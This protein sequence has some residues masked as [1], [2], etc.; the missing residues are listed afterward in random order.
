MAMLAGQAVPVALQVSGLL[1]LA[2]AVVRDGALMAAVLMV[3][4][5]TIL[6]LAVLASAAVAAADVVAVA[7]VAAVVVVATTTAAVAVA[8]DILVAVEALTRPM[9]VVVALT[10]SAHRKRILQDLKLVTA[11]SSLRHSAQVLA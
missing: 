1:R 6:G 2:L 8:A 3:A 10:A 9:V 11:K 7:A 5:A 4:S